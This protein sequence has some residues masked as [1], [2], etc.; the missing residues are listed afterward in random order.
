MFGRISSLYG[1]AVAQGIAYYRNYRR[2][3]KFVKYSIALLLLIDSAHTFSLA[4]ATIVWYLRAEPDAQYTIGMLVSTFLSYV[5]TAFVQSAFTLRV[6][7]F[8]GLGMS[9]NMVATGQLSGMHDT[10][11]IGFGCLELV[12]A[13][14]CDIMISSTLVYFLRT[15]RSGIKT[16]DSLIDKLIVYVIGIGALS[17]VFALLNLLTW[18]ILPDDVI[19]VIFHSIISKLY[20]NSLLV[21]LN[22]RQ[23]LRHDLNSGTGVDS[24]KQGGA[25]ALSTF[26]AT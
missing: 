8:G 5:T 24:T 21:T 20:V 25:I 11:S 6:W 14:I 4:N 9:S 23:R 3:P 10:I 2:D 7:I 12:S 15:S 22:S 26:A 17:S 19:F 13:M 16:S 18:L 1:V